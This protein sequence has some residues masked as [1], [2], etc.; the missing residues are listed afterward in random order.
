MED[1]SQQHRTTQFTLDA[2]RRSFKATMDKLQVSVQGMSAMME[3]TL[4]KN[5]ELEEQLTQ[6]TEQLKATSSENK[7]LEGV[8]EEQDAKLLESSQLSEKEHRS[9]VE[10]MDQAVKTIDALKHELN[11]ARRAQLQAVR[12][13]ASC[14]PGRSAT[15]PRIKPD[16]PLVRESEKASEHTQEIQHL[17]G[18][19]HSEANAPRFDPSAPPAIV[20]P[21]NLHRQLPVT[22]AQYPHVARHLLY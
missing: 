15:P 2:E 17:H 6:S 16:A 3:R 19:R 14:S 8:V 9:R 20:P 7:R 11:Q 21:S 4:T 5:R 13:A 10:A 1:E 12:T 18:A 22:L